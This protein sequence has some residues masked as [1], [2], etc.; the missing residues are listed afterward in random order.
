MCLRTTLECALLGIID[1]TTCVTGSAFGEVGEGECKTLVFCWGNSDSSPFP[2][3]NRVYCFEPGMSQDC[4]L[5][6]SIGDIEVDLLGN[7]S[8][9][10]IDDCLISTDNVGGLVCILDGEGI[11]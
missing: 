5:F 1:Y 2:I 3:D 6:S 10:N 8:K 9:L 11:F 4:I 7:A